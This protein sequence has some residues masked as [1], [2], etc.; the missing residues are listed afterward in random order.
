MV[1]FVEKKI[2]VGSRTTAATTKMQLATQDIRCQLLR[3][4]KGYVEFII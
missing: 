2:S 3:A 1:G 4:G